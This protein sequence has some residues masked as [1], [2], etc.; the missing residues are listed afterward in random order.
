MSTRVRQGLLALLRGVG[1]RRFTTTSGLGLPFLCHVG[2]F[3]GEHAFYNVGAHR[4]ELALMAAWCHHV[5]NPV[6]YDVGANIGFVSTQLAQMLAHR[7]PAII[8]F[9]PVGS[10]F[11]KLKQSIDA[12]GLARCITPLCCAV[13]DQPG[14][15]SI[16]F[17]DSR[18]LF[19]QVTTDA[20]S[21][22]QARSLS[23]AASQT[24][25]RAAE[26]LPGPPVLIKVDVEGFEAHVFRGARRLL[27]ASAPPALSFELNPATLTQVGS[28][29]AAV[30]DA[31]PG[32]AFVY[33]DDF[34][35]QLLPFGSRVDD[36]TTLAHVCN[37]FAVPHSALLSGRWDECLRVF[38]GLSAAPAKVSSA[39]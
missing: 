12:L 27:S 11:G 16:A 9:E 26:S 34:E 19:A 32:Y 25:D 35:G 14:F 20:D 3:A 18:S 30:R 31:L 39:G 5:D 17:D 6:I 23:W 22:D 37:L 8:A 33:V 15:V 28:S 10:T 21:A 13:S 36:V 29:S 38:A 24:L 2:D 7:G 4:L 1:V